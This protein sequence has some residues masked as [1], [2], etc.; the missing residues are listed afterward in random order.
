MNDQTARIG[1]AGLVMIFLIIAFA[2]RRRISY[3]FCPLPAF[4]GKAF[5]GKVSRFFI[6]HFILSFA[7]GLTSYALL[8]R[9][10]RLQIYFDDVIVRLLSILLLLMFWFYITGVGIEYYLQRTDTEY[11]DWKKSK[12]N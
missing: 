8:N 10:E 1:I 12:Y 9:V 3:L 5:N 11:E 6:L 2:L 7:I 4:T